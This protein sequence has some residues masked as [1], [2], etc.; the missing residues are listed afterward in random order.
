MSPC[1]GV[2]APDY[3]TSGKL[4]FTGRSLPHQAGVSALPLQKFSS[5]CLNVLINGADSLLT[6]SIGTAKNRLLAVRLRRKGQ[7]VCCGRQVAKD[8]QRVTHPCKGWNAHQGHS[9]LQCRCRGEAGSPCGHFMARICIK[10]RAER[11]T[12]CTGNPRKKTAS[13]DT[14]PMAEAGRARREG[15]PD[16]VVMAGRPQNLRAR[17]DLWSVVGIVP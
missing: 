7:K 5:L 3:V 4:A 11:M 2:S 8:L 1:F 16:R 14:K 6:A 12:S 13:R 15:G 10:K 9:M 17:S